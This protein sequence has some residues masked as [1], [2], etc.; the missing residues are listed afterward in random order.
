MMTLK[1]QNGEL[2]IED[3]LAVLRPCIIVKTGEVYI[4]SGLTQ[5]DVNGIIQLLKSGSSGVVT[6]CSGCEFIF[7]GKSSISLVMC[8]WSGKK[9]VS[10]SFDEED[11]SKLIMEFEGYYEINSSNPIVKQLYEEGV[12]IKCTS[13]DELNKIFTILNKEGIGLRDGTKLSVY[14]IKQY[15]AAK[16]PVYLQRKKG[17]FFTDSIRVCDFLS[18]SYDSYDSS[19]KVI[20]AREAIALM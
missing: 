12:V 3:S 6:A 14:N 16:F 7:D 10:M 9:S 20:I 11:L 5:T 19:S 4:K 15:I 13:K 18:W 1:L 2:R 8:D 17:S